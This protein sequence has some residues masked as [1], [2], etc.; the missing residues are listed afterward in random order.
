MNK[1]PGRVDRSKWVCPSCDDESI[2]TDFCTVC[3]TSRIETCVDCDNP[4]DMCNCRV[5]AKSARA[6][7]P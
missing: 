3:G 6:K 1:K 2:Q 5:V 7:K 4:V